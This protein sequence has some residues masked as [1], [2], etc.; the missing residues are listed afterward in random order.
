M[1]CIFPSILLSARLPVHHR[2]R[3]RTRSARRLAKRALSSPPATASRSSSR[4]RRRRRRR[5]TSVHLARAAL[6]PARILPTVVV[7]R[8]TARA[9]RRTR[10]DRARASSDPDRAR[11]SMRSRARGRPIDRSRSTRMVRGTRGETSDRDDD[12]RPRVA[13]RHRLD[14]ARDHRARSLERHPR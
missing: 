11:A 3:P 9:R 1:T 13:R 10:V 6:A 8:T 5:R 12:R 4:R 2:G 14:A 7:A